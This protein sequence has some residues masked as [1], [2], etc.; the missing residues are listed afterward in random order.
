MAEN[1]NI[2]YNLTFKVNP[3]VTSVAKLILQS[4]DL[5]SGKWQSDPP[6]EIKVANAGDSI[7]VTFKASGRACTATGVGGSVVYKGTD[8]DDTVYTLK[9]EIPYS[10]AN[11]GNLTGGSTYYDTTGGKVPI[12]GNSVT[13]DVTITQTKPII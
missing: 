4:Q 1:R 2:T 3:N 13:V 11:S 12:S 6:N 7:K 5:S 10:E 8:P 9:F